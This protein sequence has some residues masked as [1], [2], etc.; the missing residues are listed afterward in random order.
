[1]SLRI[2]ADENM[3]M[4]DALFGGV[5]HSIKTLPGRQITRADVIDTDVLLVRSIT[6]VDAA[7]LADTAVRFVGTAT[8]GTDH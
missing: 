6:R 5:G 1:M 7:L 2:L 4:V 8:I 3:P